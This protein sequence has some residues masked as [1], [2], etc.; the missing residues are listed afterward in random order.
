MPFLGRR[1]AGEPPPRAIGGQSRPV[2]Q[3]LGERD[4]PEIPVK[5]GCDVGEDVAD[6][7]APRQLA[8]VDQHADHGRGHR[9]GA[10]AQVDLVRGPDRLR[11]ADLA[12]SDGSDRGDSISREDGADQP[13]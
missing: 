1:L 6:G 5:L 7:R 10:G 3:E 8:F 9:L 4:L 13:G 2:G 12:N 11:G